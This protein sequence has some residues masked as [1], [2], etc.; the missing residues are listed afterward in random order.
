MTDVVSFVPAARVRPSLT[1][2]I[3]AA[4]G[5]KRPLWFVHASGR[6][7]RID[8]LWRAALTYY[9]RRGVLVTGT[10]AAGRSPED[11]RRALGDTDWAWAH[12]AGAAAGESYATWDTTAL[13]LLGK[14]W[15]YKLTDLTWVRSEEYGG[16]RAAKTHALVLKLR[17]VATDQAYWI[18]V[19]HMPL[20]NTRQRAEAWVDCCRGLQG[21]KREL[22]ARDPKA[23]F[24]VVGDVNKNLREHDEAGAVRQRL[25]KPLH[26]VTSWVHGL[27]REG[28]HGRQVIDYAIL[29]AR[30]LGGCQLLRDLPESDHRGF[31]YRIKRT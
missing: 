10:E 17:D 16:K 1:R 22:S 2:R 9:R 6:F 23:A 3:A 8:R 26:S 14:P 21:L 15:A 31:R 19:V 5:V 7:D 30:L 11:F 18:A 12:L 29:P 4:L 24:V 28:T 20:D 27:P 25:E 13:E